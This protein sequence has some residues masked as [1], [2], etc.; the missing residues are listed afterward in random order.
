VG[1]PFGCLFSIMVTRDV[2]FVVAVDEVDRAVATLEAVGFTAERHPW[3]IDFRGRSQVSLRLSFEDLY[4][5]FAG[6]AVPAD[7]HGMLLRVAALADAPGRRGPRAR[8]LKKGGLAPFLSQRY[9]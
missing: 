4:R 3:S 5:D 6:R 7:V 2:D 8:P 9:Y 1:F